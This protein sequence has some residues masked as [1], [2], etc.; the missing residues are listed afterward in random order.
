MNAINESINRPA[1]DHNSAPLPLCTQVKNAVDRY[2]DQIN[3][4]KI[5]GLHAMVISEVEKPLIE[6]TLEHTGYNQSKAAEILG[7]SRSTLR[8][9]IDHYGI[10]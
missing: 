1:L 2:F 3:G 6:S 7:M 10:T 8:K 9:K 5:A 4:H